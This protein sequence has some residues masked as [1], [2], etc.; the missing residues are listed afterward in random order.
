ASAL[1]LA[2]TPR[3]GAV[4]P[5][6]PDPDSLPAQGLRTAKRTA[7]RS[8]P[9]RLQSTPLP[10]LAPAAHRRAASGP[11]L[12]VRRLD[13]TLGRPPPT[14]LGRRHHPRHRRRT[15]RCRPRPACCRRLPPPRRTGLPLHRRTAHAT[16]P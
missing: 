2:P 4:R 1:L 11:L 9:A 7:P 10:R 6:A 12:P 13:A 16:R 8:R 3:P 15:A 14:A 5:L